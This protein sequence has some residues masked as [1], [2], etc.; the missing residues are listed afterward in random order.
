MRRLSEQRRIKKKGSVGELSKYSAEG[1]IGD[2]EEAA[3]DLLKIIEEMLPHIEKA[4]Q[5][6]GPIV[7]PTL[8]DD[9]DADF[10]QALKS[11]RLPQMSS[12]KSIMQDVEEKEKEY[13]KMDL[14]KGKP[15]KE[16]PPEEEEEE[17]EEEI[18]IP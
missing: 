1:G 16:N 3:T 15:R 6:A 8:L 18:V 14:E 2:V 9:F 11:V 7:A 5:K 17:S 10:S 12:L 13:E 4:L